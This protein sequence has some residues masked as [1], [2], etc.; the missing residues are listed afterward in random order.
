[1]MTWD[2]G[3]LSKAPN[4][5]PAQGFE[6]QG[7]RPLFYEGLPWKG[8]PTRAFA[9]YGVPETRTD[10]KLP[11]MVLV[12]GGGGT[13]FAEWVR[14]WNGRGYAAIAMD[15]CGCVPEG[16]NG[17]WSRHEFG[18]PPGWGGFDQID[19]DRE[20]QW[21]YHAVADAILAC[22]LLSSFPEIDPDRIGL[23]GISWGGY[24]TCILS[25]VA[26]RFKFAVPVYGCG[27]LGDNSVWL[28]T[29]RQMG[30]QKAGKWL[31][32]W[33]PS[34]YLKNTD[35]PMLWV[36][37]TN[38]GAYPMDSLQKSYRL[39]TGQRALCIRVRMPH[40]HGGAGENPEEIHAFAN[41]ILKNGT[42]LAEITDQEIDGDRIRATFSSE[43][44]IVETE[45]NFTRDP[46]DWNEREW[47]TETAQV[48]M[49]LNEVTA[50]LPS[51]TKVCYLNL[52]DEKALTVST[53]HMS[54]GNSSELGS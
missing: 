11:A 16:V 18:G 28:P 39:P 35:I 22:S 2:L 48:N 31:G 54:L 24:L 34:H 36:T 15:L 40:G 6:D 37:G 38:D 1:M 3:R 46:G 21:T 41:S 52:M 25:G 49:R 23:T 10:E 13:A 45:L 17:G 5:Y 26:K 20:D 43:L 12:H 44:P 50:V 9:W 30:E 19:W 47:F 53:E 42:P 27:F 51:D 8:K 29:F 33:D 14:L 7:V 4:T 32:L